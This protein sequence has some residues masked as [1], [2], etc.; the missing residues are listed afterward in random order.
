MSVAIERCDV[1]GEYKHLR[2]VS[3]EEAAKEYQLA[4]ARVAHLKSAVRIQEKALS[5]LKEKLA[6]EIK[7]LEEKSYL[8]YI[9]AENH[10]LA[11]VW[12]GERH[13]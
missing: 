3:I 2:P 11:L 5:E 9:S 13:E 1:F 8:L 7:T 10:F 6:G 12:V 4:G